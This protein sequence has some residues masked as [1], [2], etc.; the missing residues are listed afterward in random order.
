MFERQSKRSWKPLSK[1]LAP[2]A[3]SRPRTLD[4]GARCVDDAR[5]DKGPWAEDS[6]RG[7]A[8]GRR[9]YLLLLCSS[10]SSDTSA[11]CR[12]CKGMQQR[13]AVAV[14][15]SRVD[16]DMWTALRW[17]L[18]GAG[19]TC[20]MSDEAFFGCPTQFRAATIEFK[21]R[22]D[23]STSGTSRIE[24]VPAVQRRAYL[25]SYCSCSCRCRCLSLRPVV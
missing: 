1:L 10:R 16:L 11:M 7:A 24:T 2:R 22:L 21:E 14:I 13:Y 6:N 20:E 15:A 9:R 8:R 4:R 23:E 18:I 19:S 3:E 17:R 25:G 12:R 5:E